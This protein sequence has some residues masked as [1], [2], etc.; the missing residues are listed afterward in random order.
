MRPELPEFR[1]CTER[2]TA[3]WRAKTWTLITRANSYESHPM[4]LFAR[5]LPALHG[6]CTARSRLL[7]LAVACCGSFLICD[8]RWRV[9]VCVCMSSCHV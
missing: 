2:G 8:M 1:T 4:L 7:L 3:R 9:R 6:L 5:V